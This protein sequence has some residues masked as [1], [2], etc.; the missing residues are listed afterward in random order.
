MQDARSCPLAGALDLHALP[1]RNRLA[2]LLALLAALFWGLLPL[3][4]QLVVPILDTYT[5]TWCRF[6][7]AGTVVGLFLARR[8]RFG[9]L[10]ARAHR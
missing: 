3:A 1:Q 6:L 8:G 10:D 5:I 2:F 7:V 4:L 9:E